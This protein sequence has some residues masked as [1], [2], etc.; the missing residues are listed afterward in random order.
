[1]NEEISILMIL[2]EK[3]EQILSYV[4]LPTSTLRKYNELKEITFKKLNLN[5]IP[6]TKSEVPDNMQFKMENDMQSKF[7]NLLRDSVRKKN[8]LVDYFTTMIENYLI[9]PSTSKSSNEYNL[10]LLIQNL[11]CE[12]MYMSKEF[13]NE[14]VEFELRMEDI[15]LKEQLGKAE[16]LSKKFSLM[17]KED[18]INSGLIN[19]K[20]NVSTILIFLA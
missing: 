11:N 19:K 4:N 6:L 13:N 14:E 20:H 12:Y 17:Q 2:L 7:I 15:K 3:S 1:M 18:Y 8:S 16:S 9:C 10:S 5:F